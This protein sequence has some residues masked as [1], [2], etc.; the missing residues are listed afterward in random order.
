[1]HNDEKAGMLKTRIINLIQFLII[2]NTGMG[3]I[4]VLIG[5]YT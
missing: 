2:A 5:Y 3:F 1:M 4:A